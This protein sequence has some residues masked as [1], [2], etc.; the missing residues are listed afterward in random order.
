MKYCTHCGAEL[1]DEAVICPSCGCSVGQSTTRS[2]NQNADWNSLCIVG[3][4]VSFFFSVVGL[5]LSVIGYKQVLQSG[6]KGKELGLAGIVISSVK[7]AISIIII[8]FYVVLFIN[9]VRNGGM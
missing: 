4:I 3:F 7:L 2:A 6:E 9:V 1:M 5:I 8:F